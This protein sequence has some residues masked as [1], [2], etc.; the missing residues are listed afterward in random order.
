VSS[1][2]G[3]GKVKK[4]LKERSTEGPHEYMEG[5]SPRGNKR[6]RGEKMPDKK[7]KQREKGA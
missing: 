4:Y 5:K 1:S 6:L 7:G 2:K 3:G